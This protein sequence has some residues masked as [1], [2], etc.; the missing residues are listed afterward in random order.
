LKSEYT[1]LVADVNTTQLTMD[2]M[3]TKVTLQNEAL[4]SVVM[5]RSRT[6]DDLD[7]LLQ[8]SEEQSIR[9]EQRV[10]AAAEENDENAEPDTAEDEMAATIAL[11]QRTRSGGKELSTLKKEI[12]AQEK[13][14]EQQRLKRMAE[15]ENRRSMIEQ[16]DKL[17]YER[18]SQLV[19]GT[20]PVD[21]STL[22][23]VGP[24]AASEVKTQ[25]SWEDK[26]WQAKKDAESMEA[27]MEQ[28][29]AQVEKMRSSVREQTKKIEQQRTKFERRQDL[30]QLSYEEAET[31]MKTNITSVQARSKA[32][33]K[34]L[35]EAEKKAVSYKRKTM[36]E[37][38]KGGDTKLNDAALEHVK[39][40]QLSVK[41]FEIDLKE[42]QDEVLQMT[43]VISELRQT[44]HQLQQ[45]MN[46]TL[47]RSYRAPALP[48]TTAAER[49]LVPATTRSARLSVPSKRGLLVQCVLLG[50]CPS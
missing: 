42:N 11:L 15:M 5:K 2:A 41:V 14:F 20:L 38:Q 46:K 22:P 39:E 37:V 47:S 32:L 26:Y 21:G 49:R 35:E 45:S 10:A 33:Q 28:R 4:T 34:Q 30:D 18:Q 8:V 50:G 1:V 17:L 16:K 23:G 31:K 36:Q 43:R 48:L 40:L 12:E 25:L 19:N 6:Q 7:K 24:K 3:Q 44:V 9:L 13:D 29:K 27:V